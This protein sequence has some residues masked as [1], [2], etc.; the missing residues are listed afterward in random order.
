MTDIEKTIKGLTYC[1]AWGGLHECQSNVG[2][3]CPYDD[4]A[5]CE[6][7]LMRDALAMLK[8][9]QKLID[10]ITQRRANNGAFD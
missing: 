9:Q 5:D 4:E 3:D 1:T 8:K 7:S 10:E 2:D 6:L